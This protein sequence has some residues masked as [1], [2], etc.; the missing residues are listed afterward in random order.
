ME[1]RPINS[2]HG[3]Y[4]DP[5][6]TDKIRYEDYLDSKVGRY[7]IGFRHYENFENYRII[8]PDATIDEYTTKSKIFNIK[9]S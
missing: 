9:L 3:N 7:P 8:N 1:E 6:P 2:R 5:S 4:F